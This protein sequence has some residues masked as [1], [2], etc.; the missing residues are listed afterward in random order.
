MAVRYRSKITRII[1]AST[2]WDESDC[3]HIPGI[4]N[5][6]CIKEILDCQQYVFPDNIPSC[7]KETT[8][9]AMKTWTFIIMDTPH[10]ILYLIQQELHIKDVQMRVV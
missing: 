7:F 6:P 3:C 5:Y 9:G 1:R 8:I 4:E 2:L 10:R